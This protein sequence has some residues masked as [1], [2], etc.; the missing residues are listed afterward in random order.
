MSAL[1][2]YDP[3]VRLAPPA[4]DASCVSAIE[5]SFAIPCYVT[6]EQMHRIR[7][8][9]IEITEERCNTPKEGVHWL[10]SEGC[11]PQW[12]QYDARFMG[13]P[14]DPTAPLEGEP[15]FDDSIHVMESSAR[16]FVSDEERVRKLAK[17]GRGG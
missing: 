15:T 4:D 1:E 12:S 11:K 8:V 7:E 2:D 9:V 6:Q 3:E 16:G 14:V 10:C 17:R 13:K 5:I